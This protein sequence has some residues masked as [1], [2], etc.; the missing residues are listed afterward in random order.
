[1]S[2]LVETGD[3]GQRSANC[4]AK[5]STHVFAPEARWKLA[6]GVTTGTKPVEPPSPGGATDRDRSVAPPGLESMGSQSR[7][8]HHRL[9]SGVPPGRRVIPD[10]CRNFSWTVCATLAAALDLPRI[11]Y[12]CK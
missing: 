11:A 4:P 1:M 5:V 12:S 6:G 2:R 7:W 3:C 10:M 9:I 8:F